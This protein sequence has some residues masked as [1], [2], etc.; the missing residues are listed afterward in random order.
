MAGSDTNLIKPI[1]QKIPTMTESEEILWIGSPTSR[2]MFGRYM[3]GGAILAAYLIFWWA[4][5]VDRPTGEGQLAFLVKSTHLFADLTG[6]VGLFATLLIVAKFIHFQNGP[7][8]GKWTLMWTVI[9]ASAPIFWAGVETGF[10]VAGII[11]S[12]A[13]TTPAF[14]EGH[15]LLLGAFFSFTMISMSAI[16][17]RS[18]TYAITNKRIHLIKKFMYVDASSQSIGYD[19]IEN[20]I[21]DTT[22]LGRLLRF[23]TIQI[24]TASGLNVGSE[25]TSA[26]AG[27]AGDPSISDSGD[28]S[29]KLLSRIGLIISFRRSRPKAIN[30]PESCIYGI[31]SP[32]SIHQLI[33]QASDEFKQNS[34]E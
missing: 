6:V 9:S 34:G 1:R 3:L 25:T 31:H 20:L 33:N 18:F 8:S 22:V 16:Y 27:I 19:R 29:K 12:E 24:L 17:Q 21:V 30:T 2:S 7:M 23:G 5:V 14:S 28:K 32:E 10:D 26:S 4:N 15:Y 13:S 11:K